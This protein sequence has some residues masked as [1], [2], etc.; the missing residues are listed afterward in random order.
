MSLL[1][2]DSLSI[3]V[4]VDGDRRPIVR[5]VSIELDAGEALGLVGESGSG[6]SMT[7]RS[8]LRLLPRSASTRGHIRF[9]GEDVLSFGEARL[10][11]FLSTQVASI[12][13][14]P[15]ASMNPLLR[16]GDFVCESLIANRGV[17]KQEAH[18]RAI[19][20]LKDVGVTRADERM[21]Q[22]PHQLSGGLLQRVLIASALIVQPRLVLA[23]EPTTALDVTTQE[24]VVA[25]LNEQRVRNGLAMVFVT[26]DLDLGTAVCDKIAVMYAGSLVE[27]CRADELYSHAT[28]PYTRALISARP[29]LGRTRGRFEAIAGRPL[30]AYEAPSGCAFHPRC[31]QAIEECS[32][33]RPLPMITPHGT[34]SCH[35]AVPHTVASEGVLKNGAAHA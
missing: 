7:L 9:D 33:E 21:N 8:I 24:E 35:V 30:A 3:D 25:I 16:V 34:A 32:I 23:D 31:P 26:H 10:R 22:Y 2:I 17:S 5:D 1:E 13:Q 11:K 6:K 14:N 28:H 4:V 27:Q 20:I 19:A 12:F 15:Q 18:A 29:G